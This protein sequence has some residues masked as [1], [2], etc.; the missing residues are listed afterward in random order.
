MDKIFKLKLYYV[1]LLAIAFRLLISPFASHPDVGNHVDW[2]IRFF[3]YGADKFYAPESNVWAFTWPNQPPG[4]IL[5]FAS[6]RLLYG[7]IFNLFWQVNVLVP[8]FPSV[9]VSFID[10]YLYVIL[11]KAPAII[12]DAGISYLIFRFLKKYKN[13]KAA[14][15]GA[16]IFLIN[17]VVW[18][19]S[20][21]W[22]QTDAVINFFALLSLWFLFEKKPIFSAFAF[23][24]CLYI[25]ISLIIFVPIYGVLF[26]TQKF[27]IRQIVISVFLPAL[28][29]AAITI[30]FSYPENPV[31]WLSALYREKVLVNQLQVITANAFNLWAALTGVVERPHSQIVFGLSYQAWGIILFLMAYLPLLYGVWKKPSFINAV[32]VLALAS[33]SS[34]MLLTNMHERYLYPFFPYFTILAVLDKKLL[35]LYISISLINLLNLYHLWFVPRFSF[36]EELYLSFDYA[37]PR[38]LSILSFG[39]FLF[40][41]AKFWSRVFGKYKI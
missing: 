40:V 9:I 31:S 8:L 37:F 6:I 11:L 36:S 41:L 2:G 12:A 10:E 17:P 7:F 23:A 24:I 14:K 4:T 33:L 29:F 13:E 34:F 32:W 18:Y 16:V 30:P 21:L 15:L 28:F 19:N 27:S 26:F 22:G 3:E 38:I 25:K 39:I 1:F 5:I 35:P 20:A